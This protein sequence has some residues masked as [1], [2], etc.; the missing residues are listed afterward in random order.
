MSKKP[1]L[2]PEELE[3]GLEELPGWTV[4]EGK[5]ILRKILFPAFSEAISF[6]NRVAEEAEKR[7]HHPFIAIDYRRVTLRLTTWHS[8]GLTELD[9][10]SAAAYE[11]LL[12]PET[13]LRVGPYINLNK[14]GGVLG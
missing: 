4:E 8:G 9:L 6:V 11:R 10:E 14:E 2:T 7:N 13:G 5:R 3:K 12:L 1:L